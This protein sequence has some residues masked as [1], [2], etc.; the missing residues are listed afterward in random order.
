MEKLIFE[1]QTASL[2]FVK[3]DNV[4]HVNVDS[5]YSANVR[6]LLEE[7]EVEQ[8]KKFINEI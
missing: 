4:M 5:K 7:F 8:L 1:N 3:V 6:L 2:E